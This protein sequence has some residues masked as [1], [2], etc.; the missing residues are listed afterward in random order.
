VK[1]LMTFCAIM[2]WALTST[3]SPRRLMLFFPF[4][5]GSTFVFHLRVRALMCIDRLEI[6]LFP[7]AKIF[8]KFTRGL[9][10]NSQMVVVQ[11][12]AWKLREFSAKA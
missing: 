9:L 1:K 8:S 11:G 10:K 4:Q 5:V 6:F 7:S 3:K 2:W 12:Y